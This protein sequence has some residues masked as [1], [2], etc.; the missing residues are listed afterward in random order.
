[1]TFGQTASSGRLVNPPAKMSDPSSRSGRMFL[2]RSVA[3]STSGGSAAIA[4]SNDLRSGNG[5]NSSQSRKK[6]QSASVLSMTRW[7]K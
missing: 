5:R 1:M 6:S 3:S 2:H 4:A 7:A